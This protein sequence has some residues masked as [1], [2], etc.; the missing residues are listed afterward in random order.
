[1]QKGFQYT[2]NKIILV[3]GFCP[4]QS[5][6]ARFPIGFRLKLLLSVEFKSNGVFNPP[7]WWSAA[8]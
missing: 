3:Q 5:E 1:M 8:F 4:L 6:I 7:I 2:Y